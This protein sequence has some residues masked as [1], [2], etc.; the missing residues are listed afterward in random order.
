MVFYRIFFFEKG[1]KA[2]IKELSRSSES[3]LK[4]KKP[5]TMSKIS[6]PMVSDAGLSKKNV[7]GIGKWLLVTLT[8]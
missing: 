5:K 1:S 8:F 4:L 3:N 2:D 7:K 6:Y